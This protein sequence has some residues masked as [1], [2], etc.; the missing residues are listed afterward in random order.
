M[1]TDKKRQQ[2]MCPICCAPFERGEV[3]V[4]YRR[5]ETPPDTHFGHLHCV[6]SLS[7]DDRKKA[8]L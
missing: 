2:N 8:G 7:M 6:L 3:V 5:W 4:E 1:A